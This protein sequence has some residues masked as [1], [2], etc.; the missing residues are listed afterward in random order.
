MDK[1]RCSTGILEIDNVLDDLRLGDNVVWHVDSLENY[2]NPA[3]R[4]AAQAV[5][6]GRNVLYMRFAAHPPILEDAEGVRTIT[7][8]AAAGFETFTSEV[9]RTIEAAGREAFYVFD[10]LSELQEAWATDLMVGN[11]F[12]VTC[13]YLYELDTIAYFCLVRGIHAADAVT[14][15]R[16]TTQL[17]L[18][19]ISSPNGSV[20]QPVKVWQRY[21][22]TMFLP[23]ASQ[24][25]RLVPVSDGMYHGW[26]LTR[27]IAATMDYWDKLFLEA[28][29]VMQRSGDELELQ[30]LKNRLC[31]LL[32]GRDEQIL[33]LAERYLTLG[34]L[35]E[36]RHRMVGTGY[37]GGKAVGM[38][39]ARKIA[40]GID[41]E[42]TF[43]VDLHSDSLYIGSDVFQTFLISNNLW[44][45]HINQQYGDGYFDMA[46][47][48][49]ERIR[50]GVFPAFIRTQFQQV[51]DM[52]GQTPVIVRSSSLLEDGFGNAFAGKYQSVFC[53]NRGDP[54]ERLQEFEDAV[55]SV[56][57]STVDAP[58][59]VYRHERGLDK[60]SEQMSI[61]VQRVSGALRGPYH[62]PLAAGVGLSYSAYTWHPQMDPNDGMIRIVAGLGTRA[63]D[64]TDGDYSRVV[65]LG[66]P[67]V[68]PGFGLER[69]LGQRMSDVLD[70]SQNRFGMVSLGDAAEACDPE[71][72]KLVFGRDYAAEQRAREIG[73]KIPAVHVA[74]FNGL[75]RNT[76]FVGAMKEML[77]GLEKAY[78]NPV[79]VEFTVNRYRGNLSIHIVQCRP[80]QT[81]KAAEGRI[82]DGKPVV[83]PFPAVGS[84]EGVL[85]R[86]AA[87][88]FVGGGATDQIINTVVVLNPEAY[89]RLGNNER[90]SI[91][92]LLGQVNNRLRAESGCQPMLIVPGRCGTTT[93]SLGV[94]VR[95]SEIS[96]YRCIC[97]RE[98]ATSGMI[99]EL[100]FGS[101]FFQDLVES[102]IFYGALMQG[103]PGFFNAEW[104]E[105]L[106]DSFS[107]LL[108]EETHFPGMIRI[109][110][111]KTPLWL[112]SSPKDQM[113]VCWVR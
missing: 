8:D 54:D 51:L 20:F 22:P 85:F 93:P 76:P 110:R 47:E 78:S 19:L 48:L 89:S 53:V 42:G 34:D 64:R 9:H 16:E 41:T 72:G 81:W 105:T 75:F 100:S 101:H 37:I 79:D 35:I 43:S 96:A 13:P 103:G 52:F 111:F 99:P 24:D 88:Q 57:A 84:N 71:D 5:A 1:L 83:T 28:E 3:R 2:L 62:F 33:E 87:G 74:D 14:R 7:F 106:P 45:L 94:P 65:S 6:D 10:S 55:R 23:H 30:F 27:P 15:I 95:F 90:Y 17:F 18:N 67:D 66:M 39:L 69:S 11:F 73:L 25:G 77:K 98:Y 61:L 36:I 40:A 70:V 107:E 59:L 58:A 80:L 44:R 46:N 112:V 102:R 50:K 86:L 12:A 26:S 4:F 68:I 29:T 82:V 97:E 56:Y 60:I 38:L 21:T 109:Y 92:R 63:V 108:P 31:R 113:A 104:L 91:A 49:Q 32:L